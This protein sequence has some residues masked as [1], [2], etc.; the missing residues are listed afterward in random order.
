MISRADRRAAPGDGFR[1]EAVLYTGVDG[2]VAS[3]VPWMRDGVEQGDMVVALVTG[4][5]GDALRK[6][7]GPA[8]RSVD[9]ADMGST[10]SNP[11]RL[12]A[13]WR[14]VLAEARAPGRPVRGVGEPVWPGR[15]PDELVE[16]RLHEAL[17]NPAFADETA[18]WVKCLYDVGALEREAFGDV[19]TT[20]P[21]VEGSDGHDVGAYRGPPAPA[22]ILG[23]PLSA[24][25]E[26]VV[27]E[28]VSIATVR[29]LRSAV[30]S[31]A[32]AVGLG[33][34]RSRD[35]VLAVTEASANSI[36]HGGGGGTLR[37]WRT[38][39]ALVH[40]VVDRGRIVDPLVGRRQP[41]P[42]QVAGRGLWLVHE[43]CDLVQLRSSPAGT[44][45]R[46]HMQVY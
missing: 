30:H 3:L 42:E 36:V 24:P 40:E 44:V 11:G 15:R 43:L 23:G 31:R 34:Q 21:E 2:L 38:P 10:G 26:P 19:G 27:E 8:Q 1:H 33:G 32:L 5:S 12:I 46:M 37:S 17:V 25:T 6:G 20:H 7:L 35:L 14:R 4:R 13:L 9:F 41:R 16:C 22:D 18:V 29:G 45:V 39:H 28:E